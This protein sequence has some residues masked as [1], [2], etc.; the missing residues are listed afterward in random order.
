[1]PIRR[2]GKNS[3]GF[4]TEFGLATLRRCIPVGQGQCSTIHALQ[5]TPE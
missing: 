3:H 4:V 1:M 5:I 2:I